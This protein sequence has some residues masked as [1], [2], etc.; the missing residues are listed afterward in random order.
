MIGFKL[1]KTCRIACWLALG[2]SGVL[3][4]TACAAEPR[5]LERE[6]REFKVS[7]DG[8]GRGRCTLEIT[9]RDDGTDRMHI[10]AALN[11]NYVVYEYRYSSVGTEIWKDGR[12]LR[13]ENS[14]NYNGTKYVVKA[15]SRN[16]KLHVTVDDKTS[17]CDPDV[18][19]TSYWR[20]PD[21][22]AQSGAPAGKG[23]I[24]AG[25]RRPARQEGTIT[26]ALLDSD[27][28]QKL[29]G[30]V[31]RIGEVA[32]TVGGKKTSCT[33]YKISGDVQVNVWYDSEQRLV[34]QET[35]ESGHKTVMELTRVAVD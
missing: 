20:L 3:P 7:V 21:R 15:I 25:S 19:A 27:K 4:T 11:F 34:R 28:G 30:E 33:H 8:K 14:A 16:D 31:K 5:V 32:I 2:M 9:H 26:V 1:A 35:V 17:Q 10:D 18:W 24:P 12:L 29:K 23:V 22:L 13:L 6:T